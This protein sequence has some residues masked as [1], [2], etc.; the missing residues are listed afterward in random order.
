LQARSDEENKEQLPR[1]GSAQP[2]NIHLRRTV[3]NLTVSRHVDFKI[4]SAFLNQTQQSSLFI[5]KQVKYIFMNFRV[6]LLYKKK[7]RSLA[8]EQEIIF[9]PAR[10]IHVT[11]FLFYCED[12]QSGDS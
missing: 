9:L 11:V 6:P 8:H 2:N 10:Q 4:I 7:T 1:V 5:S 12:T 3:S